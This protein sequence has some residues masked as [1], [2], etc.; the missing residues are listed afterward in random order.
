MPVLTSVLPRL[1]SL[2]AAPR[3]ATRWLPAQVLPACS[4]MRPIPAYSSRTASCIRPLRRARGSSTTPGASPLAAASATEKKDGSSRTTSLTTGVGGPPMTSPTA[5]GA[6]Q[7]GA[8]HPAAHRQ[9][10]TCRKPPS[11]RWSI[12]ST[13]SPTTPWPM[14]SCTARQQVR[15]LR[16]ALQQPVASQ[17]WLVPVQG[18]EVPTTYEL[19]VKSASG[20]A[21]R[22]SAD[23]FLHRLQGPADQRLRRRHRLQ[24]G[25]WHRRR[26]RARN[27]KGDGRP[28]S[29][30]ALQRFGGVS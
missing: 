11:R 5:A 17:R 8:G 10:A 26:S 15:R 20:A 3:P 4:P 18:R 28:R 25:Q 9:P 14:R 12:C 19:G 27:W 16:R 2:V 1:N 29:A 7:P 23:V 22:I 13:A 6:V 24:R 30:A 21:G